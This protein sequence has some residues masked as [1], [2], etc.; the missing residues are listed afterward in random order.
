M[1]TVDG[2]KAGRAWVPYA[3]Y[4]DI[5]DGKGPYSDLDYPVRN[6]LYPK[7]AQRNDCFAGNGIVERDTM[8]ASAIHFAWMEERGELRNVRE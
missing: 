8:I 7:Y 6:G 1:K 3:K 4:H 2:R 5:I